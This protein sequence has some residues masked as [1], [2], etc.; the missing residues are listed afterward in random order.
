MSEFQII[1]LSAASKT[2]IEVGRPHKLKLTNEV[3]R[4]S[5][6]GGTLR[7]NLRTYHLRGSDN[8]CSLNF[9]VRKSKVLSSSSHKYSFLGPVGAARMEGV[10][11]R[12]KRFSHTAD[13]PLEMGA[14]L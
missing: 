9:L 4:E 2:A 12:I 11:E 14:V 7:T 1:G 8:K 13:L 3:I 6:L 5:L 10:G